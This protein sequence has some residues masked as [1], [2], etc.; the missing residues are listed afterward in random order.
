M[1]R[2]LVFDQVPPGKTLTIEFPVTET[3]ETYQVGWEGI[4]IPGWMEIS[5]PLASD[6]PPQP[7]EYVV[8]TGQRKPSTLTTFTC[9]FKGNTLIDITPRELGLGYPL[10]RRDH[11]KQGKAPMLK[12][13]RYVTSKLIDL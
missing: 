12:V 13:T 2:C 7:Y 3:T 5:R 10:Y 6:Q 1:G 9:H 11:Y 8:S 4:Q